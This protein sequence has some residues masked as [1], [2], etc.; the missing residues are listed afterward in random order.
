MTPSRILAVIL[1]LWS[2]PHSTI[3]GVPSASCTMSGYDTQ[4]GAGIITSSPGFNEAISALNKTCFPPVPTVIMS[5]V[6]EILLSF[7][8]FSQIAN[9]NS[10]IPS[11][12]V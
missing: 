9:F 7:L 4:K 8:N 12:A 11:T 3:I 10:T 2:W 1:K 5:G 6:H